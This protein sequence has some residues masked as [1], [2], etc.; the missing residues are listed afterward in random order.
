MKFKDFSDP[1]LYAHCKT[2]GMKTRQAQREFAGAL[3]EVMERGLHRRRGFG[4]IHEF[5]GKMGNM[6]H[7]SV[8]RIL[9]LAEKFK[10]KPNLLNLLEAG[11]CGWSKLEVIAAIAIKENDNFWADKAVNLSQM[12]LKTYI[13]ELKKEKIRLY[14]EEKTKRKNEHQN[15]TEGK[16]LEEK[17]E[18]GEITCSNHNNGRVRTIFV[19]EIYNLQ[20]KQVESKWQHFSF[21]I[22]PELHQKLHFLKYEMEKTYKK[23]LTFNEVLLQLLE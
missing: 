19:D 12:A 3:P 9:N 13:R 15:Q 20:E 11:K 4:S 18:A 16:G 17:G 22:S 5:A 10:D 2:T 8:N 7:Q 14:I 6:S 23:T 21:P 1:E